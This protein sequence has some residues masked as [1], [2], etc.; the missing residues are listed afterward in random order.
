MIHVYPE[1]NIDSRANRIRYRV[2]DSGCWECV[3]HRPRNDGQIQV[4]RGRPM[5]MSRYIYEDRHGEPPEGHNVLRTCSN[6]LCI[7]PAH[8]TARP[9]LNDVSYPEPLQQKIA[10]H[11]ERVS[12]NDA[13]RKYGVV[14][15]TAKKYFR[16][17]AEQI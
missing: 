1:E 6:L 11:A 17:H 15:R 3:S 9:F 13:A 10:A 16:R 8:L 12:I 2:T 4:K 7:N 14:W 5:L